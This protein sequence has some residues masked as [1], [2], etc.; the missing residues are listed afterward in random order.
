[1]DV[2]AS[3]MGARGNAAISKAAAT[4]ATLRT[5]HLRF[6]GCRSELVDVEYA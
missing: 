2:A 3:A 6:R 5:A 1:M 4:R